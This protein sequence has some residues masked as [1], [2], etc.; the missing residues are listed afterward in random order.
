[1]LQ[2]FLDT[3]TPEQTRA[4]GRCFGQRLDK[5]VVFRLFGDLGSGKTCFVQ[6]LAEGLGVPETYGVTSPTYTLVNEYPGRIPLFHIDLYR[7]QGPEDAE[8]IGFWEI[9]G[10]EAVVAVE[11]AE[12]IPEEFWPQEHIAVEFS[13]AD[14][15]A[16]GIHLKGYGLEIDDLIKQAVELWQESLC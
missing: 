10:Y 8:T 4:L 11:W 3:R 1:M 12:R 14:D 7:L 13:L 2:I 6:G 5:H 15:D 9:I 16:H